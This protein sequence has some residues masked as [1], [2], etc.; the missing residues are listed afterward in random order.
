MNQSSRISASMN[1]N[2]ILFSLIIPIYNVTQ[3]LLTNCLDSV[4]A[5]LSE[6]NDCECL[7]IDDGSTDGSADI[8]DNYANKYDIFKVFHKENQGNCF[9]RNH[10]INKAVGKWILFLD[11]DDYLLDNYYNN[12]FNAVDIYG[13]HF[14]NICFNHKR[15]SHKD[16]DKEYIAAKR[17]APLKELKIRTIANSSFNAHCVIWTHI[18]SREFIVKNNIKF[19]ETYTCPELH[20]YKDEDSYF[21]LLCYNYDNLILELPFYGIA[22]RIREGSTNQKQ[23]RFKQVPNG[24]YLSDL[25]HDVMNRSIQN[26]QLIKFLLQKAQKFNISL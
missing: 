15:L 13:S 8:C 3:Y 5:Q 23:Q 25:Y 12:I 11:D 7:L 10:G 19:P 4:V 17:N 14:N 20:Q 6:H 16:N 2:K 26:P 22:H 18:Y 24:Y 9:A 21:N 1:S